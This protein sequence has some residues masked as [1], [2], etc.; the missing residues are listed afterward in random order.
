MTTTEKLEQAKVAIDDLADY[1]TG[2]LC[3]SS[4]V[5][6]NYDYLIELVDYILSKNISIKTVIEAYETYGAIFEAYDDRCDLGI[7]Y[8]FNSNKYPYFVL[9][10]DGTVYSNEPRAVKTKPLSFASSIGRE[11]D[12][13]VDTDKIYIKGRG[14]NNWRYIPYSSISS[15]P[16][17]ILNTTLLKMNNGQSSTFNMGLKLSGSYSVPVTITPSS[18]K[19]TVDHSSI[20]FTSIAAQTITVTA[21]DD[22]ETGIYTIDVVA[23]GVTNTIR[24]RLINNNQNYITENLIRKR[25]Y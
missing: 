17:V 1:G 22:C 23:S 6:H 24:V 2:Y 13:Y 25:V 11:G 9:R 4:H 5:G 20:T 10:K 3:F 12:Y 19:I 15:V 8:G 14:T 21:S 18:E 16:E 7:I